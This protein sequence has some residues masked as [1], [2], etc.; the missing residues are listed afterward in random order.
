[1]KHRRFS[2]GRINVMQLVWDLGMG[3]LEKLAIDICSHLPQDQFSGSI[4]VL[5]PGGALESRVD[6]DLVDLLCVRQNCGNDPTVPFRLARLFRDRQVD[7]LHSHSWGTLLEGILASRLARVPTVI[8]SEHSTTDR[9]RRRI[10]A[11]RVGW[12]L[13]NQVV[14]CSDAVADRMTNIVNY[15]R[16]KIRVIPNGVDLKEFRR[17]NVPRCELREQFGLSGIGFLIGMV[18]RFV[19]FK[20]HAGVLQALPKLHEAG[21]D[22]HLALAGSGPLRDQLKNLSE[23][24]GITDRV[25]FLG[26]INQTCRFL[27][28]LDVF[29]SNSTSGEGLS[30][31]VLEAMACEVPVVATAVAE[32]SNVLDNGRAGSL[33]L[34]ENKEALAEALLDLAK[35]PEVLTTLGQAGRQRVLDRY[36]YDSMMKA[37]QQLYRQ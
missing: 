14:A 25:H 6:S 1:M 32:H 11:Q 20:N 4:C 30:L 26:N 35:N 31:A 17:L 27:N 29:V 21:I 22:A 24:L 19:P 10:I 3:G 18:A 28:S 5:Q 23:S 2:S 12:G 15:P 9:R 8:H 36:S 7:V 33:I 37:Y 34:P 13:V 16:K